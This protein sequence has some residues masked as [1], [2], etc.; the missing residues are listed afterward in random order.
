MLAL[1]GSSAEIGLSLV[2]PPDVPADRLAILRRAF[3]AMV[4]DPEFLADAKARQME[5]E[6]ATG[7]ALRR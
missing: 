4:A 1:Y 5:V 6:P 3:N 7:E 2:T